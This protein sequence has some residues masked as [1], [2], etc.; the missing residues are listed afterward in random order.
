ME[1]DTN[2]SNALVDMYA[3]CGDLEKVVGLFYG[4]PPAKRNASSWNALISGYDMHGFGKEALKLFSRM[5]EEGAEPNHITFTSILSACS[6]AG[7]IDEGRKCFA[8]MKR[9]SVTLEVKHHACVVDMLGRA[10][11]LLEAFDL[12]KEM[13]SPPSDGVWGALLLACKIHGNMELGKTAAS[14]LLQLEPNHTRYYVLMSNIFAGSNKWKEVGKLRQDMKNKGLKKPAAFS[15]IEYGK[16]IL[17]FHTADQENPYRH[18]VYKKMG[19]LAIEMKMAGYVPDL[20]CALHDVEEE[21][22]E[23]MLNYHSEKLA[24]E[25]FHKFINERS[26]SEMQIGSITFREVPVHVRTTGERWIQEP[27]HP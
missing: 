1:I 22:K 23:H 21:D 15:M 9:L 20:S 10:G 26:L 3:K 13:P 5:Q 14:N 4:I 25:L 8:D 19:S 2:L 7:L 18:E 6:H 24:L 27:Y 16:D 11:L 17:G 12:I